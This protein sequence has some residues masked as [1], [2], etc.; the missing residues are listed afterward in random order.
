MKG[1]MDPTVLRTTHMVCLP[2]QAILSMEA[3]PGLTEPPLQALAPRRVVSKGRL[4][5]EMMEAFQTL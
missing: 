1:A 2:H 5:E 3:K 4:N